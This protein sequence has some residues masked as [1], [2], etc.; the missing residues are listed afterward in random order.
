M[1]MIFCVTRF[2]PYEGYDEPEA[3]F[4]TK[5]MAEE[6]LSL[7]GKLVYTY[8]EI[9]ETR[10]FDSAKSAAEIRMK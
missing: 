1:K 5:E 7:L 8:Y 9:L 4:D 3:C 2:Y 6:Y 10:L